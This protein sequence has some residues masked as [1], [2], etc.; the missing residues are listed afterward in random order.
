MCDT[1][2]EK[3]IKK[4]LEE[5]GFLRME[6]P[7]ENASFHYVINYPEDHVIDIIQPAGKNDMILIACATS[8]SPEHQSGIRALSMEK[9][10]EFIWKVRFTLNRFGVDF[11]LDHPENVLNSYLVTSEIFS[12]GLS[13]DRLISSIKNVFRAKLHVMWMIQE[14]FGDDK[15][16]HDSMYV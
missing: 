3:K 16:E 12:D 13:K 15:P 14:R 1:M 11:Q 8:V 2:P 6:V 9:R 10:T 4:W 5:E 7:D